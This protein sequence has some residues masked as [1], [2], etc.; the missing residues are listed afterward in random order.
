M[1]DILK[2]RRSVR[3]FTD[4]KISDAQLEILKE[5]LLL[6][7]TSR[8]REPLEFIVVQDKNVLQKLSKS[9][10]HGAGFLAECDTAFV[11]CGD[12]DKADTCVEDASIASIIVQLTAESLELGSCWAQIRL[13]AHDEDTSAEEYIKQLMN[14]PEHFMALSVIGIGHPAEKPSPK[15]SADLKHE[16]IHIE[17][18]KG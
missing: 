14:L 18:Y 3:K 11:I 8:N 4:E 2:N 5:S 12:T 7:P 15:T 17:V 10:P 9:K 6:S 1:I 13:R 16:K